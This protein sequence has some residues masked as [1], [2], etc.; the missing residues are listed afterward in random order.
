M[1]KNEANLF[2]LQTDLIDAKVEIAV[3]K[4]IDRVIDQIRNV[5]D[6]IHGLRHEMHV[7]ISSLRSDMNNEMSILKS[8]MNNQFSSLDK[9]VVAIEICL[10]RSVEV[11]K[12][13]RDHFIDYGFK[14][15]WILLGALITYF[16]THYHILIK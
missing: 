3:S 16:V 15:S 2:Q 13:I 10:G 14:S 11:K 8:E 6:D 1:I 9:R 12:T 5:Q 7:E 4:V